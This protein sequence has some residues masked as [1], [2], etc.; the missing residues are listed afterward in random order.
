MGSE[1][2]MGGRVGIHRFIYMVAE[3]QKKPNRKVNE[4][5]LCPFSAK[6]ARRMSPKPE[7]LNPK[8]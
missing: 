4:G 1:H 8:T 7:T 5:I 3:Q 6:R 2:G